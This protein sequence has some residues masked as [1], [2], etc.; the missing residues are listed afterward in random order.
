MPATQRFRS[1]MSQSPAIV[2]AICALIFSLGSG[3][4]AAGLASGRAGAT[5]STQAGLAWHPLHLLSGWRPLGSKTYRTPSYAVRD[6]VLFLAGIA[7][8]PRKGATEPE[9]ARLPAGFRPPNFLWMT[10]FSFG[11]DDVAELSIEPNGDMFV[12]ATASA[13]TLADPSFDGI[14][15]PLNS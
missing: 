7:Q 6:G 9:I 11:S 2:I 10:C 12:Y 1:I 4:Y 13:G 15:F 8:P 5:A 14:S 3:A